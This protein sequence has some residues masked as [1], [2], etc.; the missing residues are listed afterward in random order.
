ME[1]ENITAQELN[2]NL[3]NSDLFKCKYCH[4]ILRFP[5]MYIEGEGNFC[6]S[7]ANNFVQKERNYEMENV[8]SKLSV[9]CRFENNGCKVRRKANIIVQHENVC[10]FHNLICPYAHFNEC[11]EESIV[12]MIEHFEEAHTHSI[13]ITEGD[14]IKLC[15]HINTLYNQLNLLVINSEKFL[16]H[17]VRDIEGDKLHYFI[18]YMG[19]VDLIDGFSCVIE[20]VADGMKIE[21]GASILHETDLS[22]NYDRTKATTFNMNLLREIFKDNINVSIKITSKSI[23]PCFESYEKLLNCFECPVCNGYMRPPIYQCLSGHSICTKCRSKVTHCPTCRSN[24]GSTRNYV[25]ENLS[26]G[27]K[28]PCL[29]RELGCEQYFS[30][31]D[32][33]RHEN[34]CSLKPFN[35]PFSEYL[36]CAW[37][38]PLNNVANHLKSV[39]PEQTVCDSICTETIAYSNDDQFFHMKALLAYGKVFRVCHQRHIG[40]QNGYWSVQVVGAKGEAKKYTCH[41]ALTDMKNSSRSLVRTDVCQD[42]STQDFMFNQCIVIPLSVVSWFSS[43]GK[44]QFYYKVMN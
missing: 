43:N 16:L 30:V 34:E 14:T 8:L 17:I 24:Y 23:V 15:F 26:S 10:S 41:I 21:T 38:G 4:R 29:F 39:H 6:W 3:L 5:I 12:N 36:H 2:D 1:T 7:C 31:S 25:L 40:N 18:Y 9:P 28:Y 33:S 19:D 13:I 20:H 22:P 42:L 35:C 11:N 44:L 37:D 32:I 27:V